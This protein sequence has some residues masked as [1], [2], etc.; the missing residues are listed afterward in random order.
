MNNQKKSIILP[1]SFFEKDS[2]DK[3]K[4]LNLNNLDT[5]YVFDHTVNPVDDKLAMYEIKNAV[6][7][8]QEYEDRNFNIGT[9]VLN[10]NKRKLNNLIT[11]YLNPFLEIDNFKLGLGVGDNKYQENLPNYSNSLEEV[12]IYLLEKFKFSKESRSLFLGGNSSENIKLMKKYSIGIN[13][14]LGPVK[15]IY[16]TR[17][18]Y[19][20]IK[21]QNGSISL[22]LNKDLALENK[23]IDKDIELIYIIK[24][25]STDDYKSQVDYFFK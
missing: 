3:L 12:I 23:L 25:S 15:E 18:I 11:E 13:Q 16:K 9:A 10:I 17:E 14:W 1:G 24:E 2:Q 22:C 5:V 4:Y 6:N 20:E 8:L 7:S 19:K 21:N